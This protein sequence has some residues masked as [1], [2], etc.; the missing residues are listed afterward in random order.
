MSDVILSKNQSIAELVVRNVCELPDYTSPDDQPDLVMCT[1][2]QLE[3]CVLR[4]LEYSSPET[5][6]PRDAEHCDFPDCEQHYS[7]VIANIGMVTNRPLPLDRKG[8]VDFLVEIA[9]IVK[10]AQ[11]PLKTPSPQCIYRTGCKNPEA[12]QSANCCVPGGIGT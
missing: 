7:A 5:P 4:A 2:Q 12:C 9:R 6:A 8:C 1:V 3:R 10:A 11:S